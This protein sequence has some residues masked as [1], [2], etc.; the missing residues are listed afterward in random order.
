MIFLFYLII[1]TFPGTAATCEETHL[2]GCN[3][4]CPACSGICNCASCKRRYQRLKQQGN[5]E[6]ELQ[7]AEVDVTPAFSDA[8][9]AYAFQLAL[10]A[11]VAASGPASSSIH[12]ERLDDPDFDVMTECSY[13]SFRTHNSS[14]SMQSFASV[15]SSFSEAMIPMDTIG[16]HHTSES[17]FNQSDNL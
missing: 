12:N 10:S 11:A 14:V 15:S 4:V 9:S 3:W 13:S 2:N 17:Q 1:R 8:S 7:D 16:G 5:Q 6:P